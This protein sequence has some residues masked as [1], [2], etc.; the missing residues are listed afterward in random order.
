MTDVHAIGRRYAP[1]GEGALCDAAALAVEH[2]R[3]LGAD[4]SSASAQASGGVRIVVR[5]GVAETAQRDGHQSL[6]CTVYRN[7]CRGSASS[8]AL[9]AASIRRAVEEAMAI[10]RHVQPDPFAGLADPDLLAHVTPQPPMFSPSEDDAGD[11]LDT[12]LA[13]EA[14]V[15]AGPRT[16]AIDVRVTEAGVAT[17]DSAYALATSAGFCRSGSGSNHGRWA[18]VLAQAGADAV[19][20]YEESSER[21]ADRLAC[22]SRLAADAVARTAAQLGARGL[23]SRRAP[24]ILAPRAAVDLVSDLVGALN[25]GAQY[26]GA[27]FL[28]DAIDRQVAAAHLDLVEDPYVPFGMASGAFDGEGVAGSRRDILSGGVARGYFLATASARR[29]GRQSTGNANGPWNLHLAS[30]APGGDAAALRRMMDTGLVVTRLLGGATDPVTGNWTRAV[31]GFWIER[32][33]IVHPVQDITVG[34][35]VETMLRDIVA[36]GSDSRRA[37]AITTGSILIDAMQIGGAA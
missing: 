35:R 29:L 28:P 11:L 37:G 19:Q 12:A 4:A 2:A 14:S 13:I 33:E 8:V 6:D 36:V 17:S 20:D 3:R 30:S 34:G 25:G 32:G 7:G 23:D 26:R 31:A 9:D 18:M 15:T 10:A 21:C 16:P 5:G 22:V 27:S 1:Q 24:V